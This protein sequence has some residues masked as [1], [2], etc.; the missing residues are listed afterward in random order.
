MNTKVKSCISQIS[1]VI[2]LI[3]LSQYLV[4]TAHFK[5]T[6]IKGLLLTA[7]LGH[8]HGIMVAHSTPRLNMN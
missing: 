4:T 3:I 1:Y 2:I 8:Y 5:V 7:L 6:I